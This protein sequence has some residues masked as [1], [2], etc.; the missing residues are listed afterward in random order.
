MDAYH[1]QV[2]LPTLLLGC[3]LFFLPRPL[4]LMEEL[5]ELA[6][7][8]IVQFG[9]LFLLSLLGA[10]FVGMES[11]AAEVILTAQFVGFQL[12]PLP[13]AFHLVK[14]QAQRTI[15]LLAALV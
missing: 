13:R 2:V 1:A 4:A 10:L 6:I 8:L 12:F 5:D 14:L 7:V 3:P 15:I 11:D 9:E